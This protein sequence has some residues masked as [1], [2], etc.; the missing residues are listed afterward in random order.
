MKRARDPEK[1]GDI[2]RNFLHASGLDSNLKHLEVY[3]AWEEVV[4][5]EIGTHTRAAGFRRHKLYIDV[6]SSAHLHELR[7]FHKAH[8]LKDLRERVPS[9]LI[10]DIVFRPAPLDRT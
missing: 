8:L 6:D 1:L 10:Q 4:G 7:S 2:L 9:I 3:S 5:K